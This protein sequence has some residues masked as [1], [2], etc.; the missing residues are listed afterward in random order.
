LLLLKV[1]V[2]V[3]GEVGADFSDVFL[4]SFNPFRSSSK[5][6]MGRLK[7]IVNL[8]LPSPR[9]LAWI[10]LVWIR[11]SSVHGETAQAG[12]LRIQDF[13]A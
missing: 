13:C 5:A 2:D 9:P 12:Q 10:R 6:V 3:S 11:R 7:N 8:S 1:V 4:H